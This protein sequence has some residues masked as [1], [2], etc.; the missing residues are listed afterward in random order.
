MGIVSPKF[1]DTETEMGGYIW[2]EFS[3]IYS[4]DEELGSD[5]FELRYI[6]ELEQH[7]K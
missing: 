1:K 5:E 4:V 6:H 3:V 7:N 2:N